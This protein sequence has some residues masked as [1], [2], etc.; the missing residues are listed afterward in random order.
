MQEL[1]E[2]NQENAA[3]TAVLRNQ[4]IEELQ[5]DIEVDPD[6][7]SREHVLSGYIEEIQDDLEEWQNAASEYATDP[8]E[9]R[10]VLEESNEDIKRLEMVREKFREVYH[11]ASLEGYQNSDQI[12]EAMGQ[13]YELLEED[14]VTLEAN[15][16]TTQ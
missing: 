5:R 2:D 1:F 11:Q 10:Q 13:L 16:E 8:D 12:E 14:M 3:W 4:T 15:K 6:A 9:L 7:T